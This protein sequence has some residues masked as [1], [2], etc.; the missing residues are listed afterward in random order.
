MPPDFWPFPRQPLPARE[1]RFAQYLP[2]ATATEHRGGRRKRQEPKRYS[3]ETGAHPRRLS[4]LSG[5]GKSGPGRLVRG[6]WWRLPIFPFRG[7][8]RPSSDR[9]PP[10]WA[11]WPTAVAR[12]SSAGSC[13][14]TPRGEVPERSNGAVS[15]FSIS[16]L[17]HLRKVKNSAGWLSAGYPRVITYASAFGSKIG[18][19]PP[20]AGSTPLGPTAVALANKRIRRTRP[21]QASQLNLGR[22]ALPELPHFDRSPSA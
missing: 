11:T 17:P 9:A 15:K 16:R 3:E 12:A 8:L 13:S 19:R 20:I 1:S 6:S 2:P 4:E 5:F 21:R 7:P 22:F 10:V 18:S 14:P